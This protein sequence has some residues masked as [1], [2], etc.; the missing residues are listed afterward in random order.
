MYYL[1]I[2]KRI[3]KTILDFLDQLE[4]FVEL[5]NKFIFIQSD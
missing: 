2:K 5:L 3:K 4:N 1:L